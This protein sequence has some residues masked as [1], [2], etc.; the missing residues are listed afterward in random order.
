MMKNKIKNRIN[1]SVL[2]LA[3]TFALAACSD[4]TEVE[5]VGVN[6]PNIAEQDPELYAQYL[7]NLRAY[8]DSDHKATYVWFDNSE[9]TPFSRAHHLTELPDSIDV[10]ALMYPSD[11]AAFELKEMESIRKDKGTKIITTINFDA[12]KLEYDL[13]VAGKL[14]ENPDYV[15][16]A[17]SDVMN[18]KIKNLFLDIDKYGYDGIS[19]GFKGKGT[20]HMTEPELV[21]YTNNSTQF[22]GLMTEW[23]NKHNDK[24]MVFEGK[25]QNLI[26]KSILTNCKLIILP[27]EEATNK[28]LFTYNAEMANVEGVPTD[29]FALSVSTTSLDETDTKTGYLTDQ[30]R[31]LTSAAQWSVAAHSSF[32]VAGLGIY[33]VSNDYFN[34]SANYQYTRNAITTLNPSIKN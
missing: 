8:K 19:I 24:F 22:I 10:V 29:R 17:F 15:P 18:N 6:N 21:E 12:I 4:W 26:D 9:K 30:T 7:T 14:E 16:E 34:T 5:S 13:M 3:T 20:L 28:S 25:P 27:S 31:A 1:F 2:C 11:L 23:Y 33:R 32:T